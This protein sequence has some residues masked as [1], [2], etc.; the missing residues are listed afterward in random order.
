[1]KFFFELVCGG[2]VGGGWVGPFNF[3]MTAPIRRRQSTPN[4]A[5][6]LGRKQT[7]QANLEVSVFDLRHFLLKLIPTMMA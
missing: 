6:L 5:W 4:T 1:M 7:K 3:P 2:E